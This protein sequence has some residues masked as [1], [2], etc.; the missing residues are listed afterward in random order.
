[1]INL[2]IESFSRSFTFNARPKTG[3]EIN[4]ARDSGLPRDGSRKRS[5][6]SC[7]ENSSGFGGLSEISGAS[8]ETPISGSALVRRRL[9]LTLRL[10]V[11]KLIKLSFGIN[12]YS[13][14]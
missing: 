13:V 14:W 3:N 9:N 11:S 5:N 8:G 2:I 6:A 12:D 7:G 10:V 4:G 1:M